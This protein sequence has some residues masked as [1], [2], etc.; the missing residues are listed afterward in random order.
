LRREDRVLSGLWQPTFAH[1]PSGGYL[2][3]IDNQPAPDEIEGEHKLRQ[4]G[5]PMDLSRAVSEPFVSVI[6][7]HNS[8]NRNIKF[9][10]GAIAAIEPP[11]DGLLELPT[12]G[13][14]WGETTLWKNSTAMKGN[15]SQFIAELGIARAE[16]AF[17]DY[18]R[19]VTA[20]LDRAGIQIPASFPPQI[21][22]SIDSRIQIPAQALTT[23]ASL[24]EFFDCVR[25]CVV[26]R[27]GRASNNLAALASSNALGTALLTWGKRRVGWSVSIPSITPGQIVPWQPRHAILASDVYYRFAMLIDRQL[28]TVLGPTHFAKMAA[29]WCLLADSKVPCSAYRSPE[30]MVRTLLQNRYKAKGTTQAGVIAALKATGCWQQCRDAYRAINS[31]GS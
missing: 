22:P 9:A 13:E 14:P 19:G 27:S 7:F 10:F 5:K 4:L 15:A 3:G 17:E 23:L 8:F 26:H 1:S 21:G 2:G 30:A 29:H 20:E 31:I 6:G 11:S 12:G 28:V 24:R 25:N 18:L 16:S